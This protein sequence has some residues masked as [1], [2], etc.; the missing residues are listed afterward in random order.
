MFT[1]VVENRKS[2]IVEGFVFS[3]YGHGLE[4]DVISHDYFGTDRVINDLRK[5]NTY[6]EGYVILDKS[7]FHKGADKVV[8]IG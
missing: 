2:L 4:G 6:E 3:T 7:M 8:R 1:F 5:F